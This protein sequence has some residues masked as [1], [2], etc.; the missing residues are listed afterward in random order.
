MEGDWQQLVEEKQE[1]GPQ[2]GE[3]VG[4]ITRLTTLYKELG[5]LVVA[6]G[7]V[8]DR[9]DFNLETAEEH[10]DKGVVHL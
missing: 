4:S 6:Q 9:I 7:S 10:I 3:L 5:Q 8:I 2:V 1:N